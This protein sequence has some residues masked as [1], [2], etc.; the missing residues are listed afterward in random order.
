[1]QNLGQVTQTFLNPSRL[2]RAPP[3]L[4]CRGREIGCS[5]AVHLGHRAYVPNGEPLPVHVG[6]D[7][8]GINTHH[9]ANGDLRCHAG[10]HGTL[11]DPAELLGSTSRR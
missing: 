4:F 9:L 2:L 5:I 3:D 10:L 8:R 11:E 6:L 1:M 7:Q